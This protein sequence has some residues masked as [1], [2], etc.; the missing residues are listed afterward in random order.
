MSKGIVLVSGGLDSTLVLKK[1][2][3][4]TGYYDVQPIFIDYGQYARDKEKRAVRQI[5]KAYT[6]IFPVEIK[7]DLDPNNGSNFNSTPIGSAWGRTLALVG[8]AAMWAYTHGDDYKY[9]VVG[10]H[11]GDMAPDCKPGEFSLFLQ[12]SLEFATKQEIELLYP[13]QEYSTETIGESLKEYGIPFEM[14][15]N[16]Y[17]DPPCGYKSEND[18][19]RC[20]GC[21]RKFIAMYAAGETRKELLDFPNGNLESRSYQSPLAEK[22]GN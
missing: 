10:T 7:V 4:K 6:S 15:Y 16:C 20:G 5:C 2:V 12:R 1:M 17:W 22:V 3:S 11:K 18:T 13:I 14:L 19:Y 9:I 21:R 8:L